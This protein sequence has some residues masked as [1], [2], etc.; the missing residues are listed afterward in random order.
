MDFVNLSIF[1]DFSDSGSGRRAAERE[2]RPEGWKT[3]QNMPEGG[4]VCDSQ[5]RI[6]RRGVGVIIKEKKA[7]P[8]EKCGRRKKD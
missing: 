7:P 6:W 4:W 8:D 5:K 2:N 3:I 1:Y